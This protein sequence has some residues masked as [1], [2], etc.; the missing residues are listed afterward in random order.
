MV[1]NNP[2]LDEEFVI[3]KKLHELEISLSIGMFDSSVYLQGTGI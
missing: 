1:Y 2:N 3:S